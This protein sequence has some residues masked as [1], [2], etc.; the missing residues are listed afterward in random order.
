VAGEQ[1]SA[2]H[3]LLR[4]YDASGRHVR[5][6]VNKSQL[7]GRHMVDWDGLDSKGNSTTP[8]IYF[9]RYENGKCVLTEKIVVLK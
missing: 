7:T 6:L 3:V 8:G 2:Q 9:C 4:V 1:G 5:T